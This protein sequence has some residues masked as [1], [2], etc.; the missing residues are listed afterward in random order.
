MNGIDRLVA[1]SILGKAYNVKG[2][3]SATGDKNRQAGIVIREQVRNAILF[4][5]H[6]LQTWL[7][8]KNKRMTE[9]ILK[10]FADDDKKRILS[11]TVTQ[12]E[13]IPKILQVCNLPNTSAYRK[14]R[15]LIDDGLIMPAG[16]ADVFERRRAVLY[17]TTIQQIQINI[18]GNTV[19]AKIL[20]PNEI[21]QSSVFL[22][23]DDQ[24][25]DGTNTLVN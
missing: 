14:F 10:S 23:A 5:R 1:K 4:E 24:I 16:R 20:V 17:R 3:K 12:S 8:L 15:Q 2:H 25:L 7:V 18:D 6:G 21:I 19:T 11:L 22:N 9:T 13:T